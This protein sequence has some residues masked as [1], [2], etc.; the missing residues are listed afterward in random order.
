MLTEFRPTYSIIGFN[1]PQYRHSEN[2]MHFFLTGAGFGEHSASGAQAG[3]RVVNDES[4]HKRL[5][6]LWT[7]SNLLGSPVLLIH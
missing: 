3:E 1:N 6:V 2:S 7:E 4:A 5:A